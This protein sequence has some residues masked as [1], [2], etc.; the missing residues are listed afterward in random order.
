MRAEEGGITAVTQSISVA[1]MVTAEGP[2]GGGVRRGSLNDP[3]AVF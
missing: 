1:H 2:G 3:A